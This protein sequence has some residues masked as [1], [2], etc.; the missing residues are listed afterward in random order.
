MQLGFGLY[1]VVVKKFAGG[2]DPVIFCF[3][4]DLGCFPLLLLCAFIVE[5]KL[6]LPRPRMLLIFLLLGLFGMLGSQVHIHFI[7][8]MI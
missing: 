5:R 7:Q 1:P 4:R 8:E 3:Y 2:V 6:I